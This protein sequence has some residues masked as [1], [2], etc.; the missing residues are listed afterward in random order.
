MIDKQFWSGRNVFLTGHTGFKG[1]W[2]SM[3]L[4]LLGA[5]VHGYALNPEGTPNL[6]DQAG[7]K[8]KLSSDT[9]AS[10]LEYDKLKSALEHS[11]ADIVVHFAAQ[12]LVKRSYKEPVQTFETNVI[13]TANMLRAVKEV[14]KPCLFLIIT[15][16]KV[17]ENNEWC[18]GYREVDSLGGKDPY[19]A[20]KA[21]CELLVNSY[22][23]SFFNVE[24]IEEH[25]V[26]LATARAG[27][28]I[29]G[30][31]WSEDRLVPDII[32]HFKD[33][34]TVLVRSPDAV[35]PW[36][37]VLEPLKQYSILIQHMASDK[38]KFAEAWNFGPQPEDAI[39]V[40]EICNKVAAL[41][42]E[43]ATWE[44]DNKI[45]PHEAGYL[46]LDIA[47]AKS[48]LNYKPTLNIDL[49]LELTVK[50]YKNSQSTTQIVDIMKDQ[51]ELIIE[52]KVIS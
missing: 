51:I 33:S 14:G 45:H 1:S 13:G 38:S 39:P 11:N 15:T 52:D 22:R 49:A 42:G 23:H 10:I 37:H 36:E 47:K 32:R 18:W 34:K 20:S 50:W 7:I 12:A 4:N 40:S 31:D 17:Y 35:R 27:N 28:V 29:G 43:G 48:L 5:N 46:Y 16:D 26:S 3:M 19:S 41:W 25:G 8:D 6:F 30:G 44:L 9:R 2:Y 24:N 21:C